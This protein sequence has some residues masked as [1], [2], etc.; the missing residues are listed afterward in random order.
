VLRVQGDWMY[1]RSIIT[2]QEGWMRARA[3]ADNW[4]LRRLLPELGYLDAVAGYLRLRGPRQQPFKGDLKVLYG[5][6]RGL[7]DGYERA[8]GRDAAQ[9]PAA[10]ARVILG[11]AQWHT[12]GLGSAAERRH[13]ASGLFDEATRL[14]P[15]VPDY[16]NFSAVATPYAAENS[17][18]LT[19][20]MAQ[21]LD[22]TLLGVVALDASNRVALR[23]L[24]RLYFTMQ[25][26][27]GQAGN[28]PVYAAPELTQ[29]LEIVRKS[30]EGTR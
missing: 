19:R 10:L 1:V 24:E 23:N 7:F 2:N 25:T 8:V 3:D 6:V 28:D 22:G 17:L 27:D 11:L 13:V 26:Q 12:E 29:R 5:W 16:R 9:G 20:A 30:L 4:A 15:E 21:R 18:Q 14:A